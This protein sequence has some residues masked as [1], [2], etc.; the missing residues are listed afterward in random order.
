MENKLLKRFRSVGFSEGISYLVLLFIAMP[1]KYVWMFPLAVKIV[2]MIHGV[3]FMFYVAL[4]AKAH[5]RYKWSWKFS[6]LLFLASLLPFG[7][8]Y[9]DRKL[10]LIEVAEVVKVKA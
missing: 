8:F 7:T 2:G 3:L 6:A 4:L 9:T 1:L 5:M 10:K